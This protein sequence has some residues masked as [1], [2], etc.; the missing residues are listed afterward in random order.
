MVAMA[1]NFHGL[2]FASYILPVASPS[3]EHFCP[4][5]LAQREE[6]FARLSYQSAS[7]E[8][9][10]RSNDTRSSQPRCPK[11]YLLAK[12]PVQQPGYHDHLDCGWL[13]RALTMVPISSPWRG[14]IENASIPFFRLTGRGP[15]FE[16]SSGDWKLIRRSLGV[17]L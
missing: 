13:P 12:S 16:Q 14:V 17:S 5:Y 3:W 6:L 15:L 2:G 1:A 9:G 8:T 4:T 11:T 7:A 10:V